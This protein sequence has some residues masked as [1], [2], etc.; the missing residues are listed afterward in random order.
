MLTMLSNGDYVNLA[1]SRVHR[2]SQNDLLYLDCDDRMRSAPNAFDP[3]GSLTEKAE[4]CLTRAGLI[5]TLFTLQDIGDVCD[6]SQTNNDLQFIREVLL[7][8]YGSTLC[9][10]VG[11]GTGRL[12]LPLLSQGYKLDGVDS[13]S[14][15][16]R[17]LAQDLPQS[18][19]TRLF[20]SDAATFCSPNT[21]TTAFAALNSL[22]YLVTPARVV[23]HLRAMAMSMVAGGKY[24]IQIT[25][26][27]NPDPATRPLVWTKPGKTEVTYSWSTA[28]VNFVDGVMDE[29]VT[30]SINKTTRVEYQPQF[31]SSYQWISYVLKTSGCWRIEACWKHDYKS[32]SFNNTTNG[33]L[34]LLLSRI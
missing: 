20:V 22:R 26:C 25:V 4:E 2:Y 23:A 32:A 27:S 30:Y 6:A 13:R 21:Y 28:S 12:L 17:S 5:S 9:L 10:D 31:L 3:A 1:S 33:T 7:K 19:E 18:S 15:I 14:A 11:C 34:W 24:L 29:K 8:R 16:I